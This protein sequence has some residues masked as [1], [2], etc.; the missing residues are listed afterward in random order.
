LETLVA[1]VEVDIAVGDEHVALLL[2]RAAGPD[3]DVAGFVGVQRS[4]LALL[5]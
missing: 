2:L 1:I 5:G 3:F 4:L